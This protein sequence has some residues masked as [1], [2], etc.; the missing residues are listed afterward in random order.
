MHKFSDSFWNTIDDV[1][2]K[3]A[4]AIL[5]SLKLDSPICYNRAMAEDRFYNWENQ[6]LEIPQVYDK[7]PTVKLK[8]CV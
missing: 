4:H 3:E 7:E 6:G 8:I 2:Y 5:Y 1:K